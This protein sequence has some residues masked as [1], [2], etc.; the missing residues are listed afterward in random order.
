MK[1]EN[2]DGGQERRI[3]TALVTDKMV[4]SRLA[5]LWQRDLFASKYASLV[6]G[7]CVK[8]FNEYGDAPKRAI[9]G[10]FEAWAQDG[11]DKDTIDIVD[12]FLASLSSEYETLS[13]Q[14]NSDYILDLAAKHFNKVK[15]TRLTDLIQSDVSTGDL[16]KALER[17]GTFNKIEVGQGAGIDV[18]QDEEAIKAAFADK[19]EPLVTY[20]GVMGEFFRDSLARDCFVA[21]L[22]SSKRGKS[23]FLL[24]LAYRAMCQRR[25]VAFFEAGDMSQNQVMRRFMIRAAKHPIKAKT[26]RWPKDI[27]RGAGEEESSVEY[28]DIDYDKPL[29]WKRAK[30]ACDA[31]ML[32]RVKSKDSYLRLACYPTAT[33]NVPGIEAVLD[34]WERKD[35]YIPD[36]CIIDYSDLLAPISKNLEGR[37]Q[38]NETW[39]ALRALSQSRHCLVVTATQANAASFKATTI[40]KSNFSEDHR[41]NAQVTGMIGLSAT[42]TEKEKGIMRLNWLAAREMDFSER[43]CIH[44]AGCL[45]LC[46]PCAV[47]TW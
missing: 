7:W 13:E 42:E 43:K 10:I 8:Y 4:L 37:D 29:S 24:D 21:F 16:D 6:G 18:L 38:I 2:F 9:E 33:I 20:P 26:V 39:K 12:K 22:A 17:V 40:S 35:D 25:R 36:V 14:S 3:I 41:K 45:D 27:L 44:I 34:S 32:S 47:A 46:N 11:K 5:P 28:E 23:F 19:I 1:T 31:V 30:R 15:L